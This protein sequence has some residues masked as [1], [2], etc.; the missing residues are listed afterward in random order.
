M[1]R[2]VFIFTLVA[3][4]AYGFGFVRFAHQA[5]GM[6]APGDTVSADAIVALTGGAGRVST[7]VSLLEQARGA[8]LL[9][10]GVHP[11]TTAE[12]LRALAGG[13]AAAFDCCVDL[14]RRARTTTGNASETADWVRDHSYG[15][16][17]IVTSDFHMR[18]SLIMLSATLGD[19]VTLIA[20]P[21]SSVTAPAWW[22][23]L[24]FLRRSLV[25]YG[26][27][28]VARGLLGPAPVATP[29]V[30]SHV[31]PGTTHAPVSPAS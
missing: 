17:L 10:S 22:R 8:R 3:V 1:R 18:R 28:L 12:D 20:Y 6:R 29:D 4:A 16:L 14:G 9:I 7:G 2:L 19:E 21:V 23:D 24:G 11:D 13:D 27:Y 5:A 31:G 26:K 30:G 25:E 15:S